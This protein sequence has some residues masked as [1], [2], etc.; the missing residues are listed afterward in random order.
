MAEQQQHIEQI[1]AVATDAE[2]STAVTTDAKSEPYS[3]DLGTVQNNMIRKPAIEHKQAPLFAYGNRVRIAALHAGY[4]PY[5]DHLI[6]VAGWARSTRLGGDSLF[7]IELNDGSSPNSLQVVVTSDIPA[8]AEFSVAKVGSS[9][10]AT[11]KLIR[12]PK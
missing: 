6:S 2:S 8:F 7:F 12:S 5:L 1:S 11:G 10:S 9:F 4:E 3:G